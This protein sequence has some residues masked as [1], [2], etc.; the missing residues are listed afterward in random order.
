MAENISEGDTASETDTSS[1]SSSSSEVEESDDYKYLSSWLPINVCIN[2]I[3]L[4]FIK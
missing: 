4:I 2:M 3:D 1:S